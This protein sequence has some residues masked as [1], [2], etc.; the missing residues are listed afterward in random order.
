MFIL[1]NVVASLYISL[2]HIVYT[3]Y[4]YP[5]DDVRTAACAA[6]ARILKSMRTMP[7]KN[8]VLKQ[9]TH[10]FP[11]VDNMTRLTR[12]Y[13]HVLQMKHIKHTDLTLFF[14]NPEFM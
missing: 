12:L 6:I 3:R 11:D 7:T 9:L 13:P 2:H 10:E 4:N 5:V 14:E 8:V 1:V